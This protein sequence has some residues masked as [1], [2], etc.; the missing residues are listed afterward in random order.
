MLRVLVA[1]AAEGIQGIVAAPAVGGATV[2]DIPALLEARS[3]DTSQQPRAQSHPSLADF[4]PAVGRP[5]DSFDS[6]PGTLERSQRPDTSDP[7][8]STAP[9]RS[10]LS[11][12]GH[13]GE[14]DDGTTHLTQREGR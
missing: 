4:S 7:P 1:A 2:N 8:T 14:R 10:G 13:D 5:T 9:T 11:S 6:M 12:G 3:F